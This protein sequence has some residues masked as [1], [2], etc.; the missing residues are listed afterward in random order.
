VSGKGSN[1]RQADARTGYWLGALVLGIA[2]LFGLV[3]MPWASKKTSSLGKPAP[4]FAL[5]VINGK[6]ERPDL[7][8]SDL[9][10][11]VVILDFWASWCMPCRAQAPIVERV[12]KA[13]AAQGVVLV[14]IATSD[15]RRSAELYAKNNPS[16][17]P[18]LFDEEEL[19]ARA[20]G[21]KGLP[22]LAVIDRQG[23]L[24]ALRSGLVR[25]AELR[26]LVES[27]LP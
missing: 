6:F 10:G 2:L 12:A 4:E 3:V 15:Q 16:D 9:D 21:V 26:A 23:K 14:G 1:R 5:P 22:T 20:Y 17:F 24:V 19:V 18:A 8:L 13:H 27:A 7:R 11:K 25:E